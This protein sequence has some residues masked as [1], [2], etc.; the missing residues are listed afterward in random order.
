MK[1]VPNC[2]ICE[3][4]LLN[5]L[6]CTNKWCNEEHY[7]CPICKKIINSTACYEYRGVISCGD[8]YK[9]TIKKRDFQRQE[10]IEE[11]NNKTKCFK[12]LDLS[13]SVI[14]KGN[15]EILKPNI[16]IAR[17]ESVR[18]KDYE[19]PILNNQEK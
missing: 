6:I 15:R 5:G 10:I 4:P 2:T 8:C 14:G 13:D 16:E 18:L 3:M 11:E 17:K 7:E 12:G 9:E 19:Q 1:T